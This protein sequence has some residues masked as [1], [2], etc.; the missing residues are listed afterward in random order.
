MKFP[1]QFLL[2]GLVGSIGFVVD[3]TV[4]YLLRDAV[5]LYFGRLLSF[6]TSVFV[7]WL[8]NRNLTF[9]E[10]RSGKPRHHELAI[11]FLLMLIGG[12]VNYGTYAA[13]VSQSTLA[14]QQPIWGVAAGSLAGMVVN[15][16]SSRHLLFKQRRL[17]N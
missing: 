3:S 16:L 12:A 4:L 13:L 14:N 11:Y 17:K 10:Q 2:F 8:L 9:A 5:G 6:T 1:R 15:L 7:T